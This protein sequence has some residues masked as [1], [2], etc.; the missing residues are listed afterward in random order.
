[1]VF[2]HR[3]SLFVLVSTLFLWGCSLFDEG[4]KASVTFCVNEE[5]VEK[6]R[7][8]VRNEAGSGLS[9]DSHFLQ[10][11]DSADLVSQARVLTSEDFANM[12]VDIE[13][14]GEYSAKRRLS[15]RAGERVVFDDIRIGTWLYAQA[16]AYREASGEN[17][18]RTVYYIGKSDP[19]K[20]RRGENHIFI[21]M[22]SAG[23]FSV[24]VTVQKEA[25]D[26]S[27]SYTWEGSSVTFTAGDG[28]G[29]GSAGGK[30]SGFV[31][32]LDGKKQ[33]ASGSSFTLETEGMSKGVYEI[34]VACGEKSA[35]ATV[36]IE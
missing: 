36:E 20:I 17:Q 29:A 1:M 26:L 21:L 19:I 9:E 34:E 35:M 5:M 30:D 25:N 22:K 18:N 10:E 15:A 13:L 16:V 33:E 28:S 11:K 2:R 12:F 6:L 3:I 14:K 31:W 4:D 23:N 27:L 8:S 7:Q 24:N 32:Y